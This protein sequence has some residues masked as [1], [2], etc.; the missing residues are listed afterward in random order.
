MYGSKRGVIREGSAI[1]YS[2]VHGAFERTGE[3]LR[4]RVGR[5]LYS[6]LEVWRGSPLGGGIVFPALDA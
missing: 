4:P 2:R 5:L 6:V 1:G 3:K